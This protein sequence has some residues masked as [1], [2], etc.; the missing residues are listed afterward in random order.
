MLFSFDFRINSPSDQVENVSNSPSMHL[1]YIS[2]K[3]SPSIQNK[4]QNHDI[5]ANYS[6]TA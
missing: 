5:I 1:N 4:S 6:Q 3:K 2:N